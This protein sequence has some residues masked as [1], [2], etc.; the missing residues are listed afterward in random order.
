[1]K[2]ILFR[3]TWLKL[4][5]SKEFT[6]TSV[7]KSISQ[8]CKGSTTFWFMW[9]MQWGGNHP[10]FVCNYTKMLGLDKAYWSQVLS[11][12]LQLCEVTLLVNSHSRAEGDSMTRNLKCELQDYVFHNYHLFVHFSDCHCQWH[13]RMD[14]SRKGACIIDNWSW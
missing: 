3:K 13:R 7:Q 1:M 4:Q 14:C 6:F 11:V 8:L 12:I 2:V 10:F 5:F 9:K